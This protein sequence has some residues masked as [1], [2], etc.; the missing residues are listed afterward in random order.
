MIGRVLRVTVLLLGT[1]LF[2]AQ[3]VSAATVKTYIARR[4]TT[5][6][7]ATTGW[8]AVTGTAERGTAASG[9]GWI[10]GSNFTVGSRYLIM[11]WGYHGTNNAN[12]N[13]GIRV[14]HGGSAFSESQTVEET[15][16]TAAAY[17]QPYFWFTV[18]TAA[19]EDVNVEYYV[20]GGT[21]TVDDIT[22]VAMNAEGRISDSSLQYTID[23]A[24]GTLTYTATTKVSKTWTPANNGDTWWVGAYARYDINTITNNG[25]A[26]NLL[27]DASI[28]G[29]FSV[30]GEDTNDT[31]VYSSSFA[32]TFTNASHTVAM[33]LK[34]T[35]GPENWL[36]AGIFALR[37]NYFEDFFINTVA[38][39][40]TLSAGLNN[41][42]TAATVTKTLGKAGRWLV[43]GGSVIDDND[44]RTTA[45]LLDGATAI[46][47]EHGGWQTAIADL[48]PFEA[49]DL[50][51]YAAGVSHTFN[52]R[53]RKTN[54]PSPDNNPA[55][56]DA[57]LVGLYLESHR[58]RL[59][60]T[61]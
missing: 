43:I 22:L 27:V 18:W 24:G 61:K 11:V 8:S 30:D 55:A 16:R 15:D 54:T 1:V 48:E 5:Q 19:N 60:Q 31:P 36:A 57:W 13:S 41:Y 33:Q 56:V 34:Q 7:T 44:C 10:A 21:G 12:Q 32:T 39:S 25:V 38:G 59:M 35:V 42:N 52:Y 58:G 49:A 3:S 50:A 40:Q 2:T 26:G 47:T 23:T 4:T 17:K 46:T 29:S 45:R 6:S 37:L 53:A 51:S 20:S 28:Y 9:N 14:T